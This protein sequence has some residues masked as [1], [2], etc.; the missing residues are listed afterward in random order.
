MFEIVLFFGYTEIQFINRS[1]HR[2]SDIISDD[3]LL[4][5]FKIVIHCMLEKS[6]SL[7]IKPS[8]TFRKCKR[9]SFMSCNCCYYINFIELV[10]KIRISL[11]CRKYL[12][13]LAISIMKQFLQ[14][15]GIWSAN[16]WKGNRM[17]V[18]ITCL[19]YFSSLLS[20]E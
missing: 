12:K 8:N 1:L 7:Q 15:T 5:I 13:K 16:F 10:I 14:K 3:S 11:N 20:W 18:C 2:T 9:F 6:T 19:I 17:N 4:K